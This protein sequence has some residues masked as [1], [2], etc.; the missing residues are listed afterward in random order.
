MAI[1]GLLGDFIRQN[2]NMFNQIQPPMTSVS[3]GVN[4]FPNAG[5]ELSTGVQ[6]VPGTNQGGQFVQPTDDMTG[7]LI[8]LPDPSQGMDR[9]MRPVIGDSVVSEPSLNQSVQNQMPSSFL[10][11]LQRSSESLNNQIR[12]VVPQNRFVGNQFQMPFNFGGGGFGN[13]YN[14]SNFNY[15]PKAFNPGAFN[16]YGN[17]PITGN[18]PSN[19]S[20]TM[21]N[22]GG[23]GQPDNQRGLESIGGMNLSINP[24]TGRIE[25]LEDGTLQSNLLT[26][27]AELQKFTPTGLLSSALGGLT[28][29]TEYGRQ[30]DRIE[31]QFGKPVADEIA[32]TVM[33][34]Y[35]GSR[36]PPTGVLSAGLKPG[37]EVTSGTFNGV[38]IKGFINSYGNFQRGSLIGE[39]DADLPGGV[40]YEA[41]K[42]AEATQKAVE[43]ANRKALQEA[44]KKGAS[45]KGPNQQTR[46]TSNDKKAAE[47]RES[48]RGRYGR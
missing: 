22:R 1:M 12:N 47:T 20:T 46:D 40:N 26:D 44:Q 19:V 33:E 38:P 7:G 27:I 21:Q 37:T 35:R 2:P 24:S 30:L 41:N 6:V 29:S 8:S 4:S 43:E 11:Q 31:S 48:F 5:A 25:I 32:Q 15:T 14:P 3:G 17:V 39:L 13:I 16:Q 10:E 18:I 45:G 23:G 9:P 36:V 34:S 42:R 28:N